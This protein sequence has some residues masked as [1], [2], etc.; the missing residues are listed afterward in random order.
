[1]RFKKVVFSTGLIIFVWLPI[2]IGGAFLLSLKDRIYPRTFVAGIDA[3]GMTKEQAGKLISQKTQTEKPFKIILKEEETSVET[4][5]Q[6][7]LDELGLEYRVAKAVEEAYFEPRKKKIESLSSNTYLELAFVIDQ[8]LLEE[9]LATI[10]AEIYQA[11]IPSQ[12][13]FDHQKNEVVFNL[14][15][16]G[17]ELDI[18]DTKKAIFKKV[19]QMDFG[20]PAVLAVRKLSRLPSEDQ[21]QKA[22]EKARKLSNKILT[23]ISQQQNFVIENSQLIEFVGLFSDWKKDEIAQYVEVLSQSVNRPALNALFQITG[24]KIAVFKPEQKG[25]RLDKNKSV[26]VIL[27]GLDELAAKDNGSVAKELPLEELNPSIT[28][29]NTNRLGI[30]ALIGQGESWFSHS[31]VT[32]VHNIDLASSKIHGYLIPPGEVFSINE[33]LGDISKATGYQDAYIIKDGKTILGAGGGVC[34][35]STTLFRAAINSGLPI[36]ERHAHAYRV[37]YYE[38]N[39]QPGFDATVFYPSS[40]LKFKNDS[41]NHIL[42]QRAFD[43]KKHYLSFQFYGSP[44]GRKVEISNVRLW[45]IVPPPEDLYI[46]DP[47]LAAGVVRQIDFKAWGAKAA[48]DW[49]VFNKEGGI[50]QEQTFFSNYRPWRAVFLRGSKN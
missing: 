3:G 34:Q 11:D 50:L 35:V 45:G 4:E 28:A 23:L 26:V 27:E 48:F 1:M 32:R 42:I 19:G 14:G 43:A 13:S 12:I 44:D 25:F 21:I 30:V 39:Y 7:D 6:I 40:D 8:N 5:W 29:S 46:D 38:E 36:T 31:I 24:G 2:A 49:K 9:K 10:A 22:K 37:Y 15:Q 20:Q 16:E 33:V 17:K 18:E 47:T 41:Q